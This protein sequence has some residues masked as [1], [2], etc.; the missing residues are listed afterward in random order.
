MF[1]FCDFGVLYL[2]EKCCIIK[3]VC[4]N[5]PKPGLRN[6]RSRGKN[7]YAQHVKRVVDIL[8]CIIA[9]VL[10]LVPMAVIGLIIK[11]KDPK[12]KII[13]KQTRIGRNGKRFKILKFRTMW[14]D[15][16]RHLP[17]R[18]MTQQDYDNYVMPFGKWLRNTSLDELPQIIN[19]LKGDMSWVGPRPVI[20][21]ET[22]LLNARHEAGLD[23]FRPGLT[24]WAQINGRNSLT[25]LEKA[26]YDAEYVERISLLFDLSCMLRTVPVLVSKKGY[27]AGSERIDRI[28][29]FI[30]VDDFVVEDELVISEEN[31][32]DITEIK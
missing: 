29:D 2:I 21:N 9:I 7:M 10:L 8:F 13:F 14:S 4:K 28:A 19:I 12:G 1:Y 23:S 24:G 32:S 15:T 16:P 11:V 18:C 30:G 5:E 22:V 26:K 31:E 25:D 6:H 17:N 20:E 27:I 3:I